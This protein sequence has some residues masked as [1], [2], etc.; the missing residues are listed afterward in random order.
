MY[1]T[2][3]C[4]TAVVVTLSACAS[5]A[6]PSVRSALVNAG[7][8]P[9]VADCMAERMT[10]QLSIAQLQRLQR[11]KAAPG[12]KTSNLSPVEIVERISRSGDPEVIAVTASA[13]AVCSVTR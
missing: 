12:E 3:S 1:R 13:G 11:V 6:K 2:L 5:M 4:L 7:A 8:A 9:A 10:D